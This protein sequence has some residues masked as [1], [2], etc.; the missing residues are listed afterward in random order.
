[1]VV[2]DETMP[3]PPQGNAITPVQHMVSSCTGAVL[4]SLLMTPFDVVKIR[5]QSQSKPSAFTKGH[6]FLYCNGLMDHLCPCV[7][8]MTPSSQWYYRPGHF[9][10]TFDAMA[11]I[12]RNEGLT[13][14]W[15]GLPPTLVMAVPATVVYFTSYEQIKFVLGY[16]D[17]VVSYSWKPMVAGAVARVWAASLISPIEMVRTKM[18]STK[19]NYSQVQQA[20][21]ET[22]RKNG[23]LSLWKG[24]GPTLLRDVPFSAMY[25][26]GY[27][28]TKSYVLATKG[29]SDLTFYESFGA[30]ALAGSVAALLTLPFDVIK[31]R[32]QIELGEEIIGKLKGSTS[33]WKIIRNIYST[34]GFRALF[35]GLPP[36]LLKVAPSCAIMISTFEYFKRLFASH[37]SRSE[38]VD[39]RYAHTTGTGAFLIP[40]NASK[41][42]LPISL[43][44]S[45]VA[46]PP[47]PTTEPSPADVLSTT[48][49]KAN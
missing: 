47:L 29:H 42:E 2:D 18:Q 49:S 12:V 11:K 25:W 26:T 31:T 48:L 44:S 34:E 33:T 38:P 20:V 14:L 15:S 43:V 5:L 17:G 35:A 32:R 4:T 22:I 46:S 30:G 7:S 36:R 19:I 27:E 23:V 21:K 39:D 45:T 13:S 10:G 37:N 8:G 9:N 6:C 3:F 41:P 28:V 1:M 24:L 40:L 16:Q